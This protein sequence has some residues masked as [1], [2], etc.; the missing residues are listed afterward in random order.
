[1][2]YILQRSATD[3]PDIR[4]ALDD[5]VGTRLHIYP[6]PTAGEVNIS[7]TLKEEGEVRVSIYDLQ[8]KKLQDLLQSSYPQ[9]YHIYR[10]IPQL[11][12]GNYLVLM[13]HK[14]EKRSQILI[15]K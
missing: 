4:Q 10:F 11:P 3:I 5:K 15:K 6:N 1:M 7:F 2:L 9:G 13:E 8:G 14:G 12:E